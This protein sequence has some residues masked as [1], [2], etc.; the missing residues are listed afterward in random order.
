METVLVVLVMGC[1]FTSL[2]HGFIRAA[3]FC[4]K[5]NSNRSDTRTFNPHSA[6]NC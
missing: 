3:R 5:P 2:S 1:L 4:L 6:S